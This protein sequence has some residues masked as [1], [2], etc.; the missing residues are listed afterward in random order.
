MVLV[1]RDNAGYSEHFAPVQLTAPAPEGTLVG[2]RIDRREGLKLIGE[3]V[4]RA[5]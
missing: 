1:E 4:R 3:P 5:A 2:V